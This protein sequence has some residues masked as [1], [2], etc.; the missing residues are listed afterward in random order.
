MTITVTGVRE[1]VADL[2][3]LGDDLERLDLSHVGDEAQAQLQAL[4]PV[5][6]GVLRASWEVTATAGSISVGSDLVYAAVQNFGGYHNIAGQHFVERS[7]ELI[8]DDAGR[9]V[10]DEIDRLISRM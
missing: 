7:A 1:L 4:S 2:E 5:R 6:T 10:T 3:R 9:L 8:T